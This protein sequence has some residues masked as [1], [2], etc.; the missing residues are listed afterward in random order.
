M[1]FRG[2]GKAAELKR[3]AAREGMRQ[4]LW[5]NLLQNQ[6]KQ[7]WQR[8]YLEVWID[9]KGEKKVQKTDTE[10]DCSICVVLL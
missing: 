5:G 4:A 10:I 7:G 9:L 1:Y 3:Q 2:S 8:Q 6:R